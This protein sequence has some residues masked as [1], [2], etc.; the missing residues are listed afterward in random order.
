MQSLDCTESLW[1]GLVEALMKKLDPARSDAQNVRFQAPELD[2][3]DLQGPRSLSHCPSLARRISA[4]STSLLLGKGA[5]SA[6]SRM[7]LSLD[8]N[9]Q[10]SFSLGRNESE[11]RCSSTTS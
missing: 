1:K 11:G 6:S 3:S 7:S 5:A 9:G 8:F 2:M 4:S 10:L